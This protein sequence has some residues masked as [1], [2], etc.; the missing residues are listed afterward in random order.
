[1]L[2]K[3]FGPCNSLLD[4]F[5]PGTVVSDDLMSRGRAIHCVYSGQKFAFDRVD[6]K[7]LLLKM[8]ELGIYTRIVAFKGRAPILQ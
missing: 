8:R 7:I 3:F 2:T 6:H 4:D 5:T 1:M